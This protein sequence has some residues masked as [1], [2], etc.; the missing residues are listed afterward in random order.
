MELLMATAAEAAD[1][2]RVGRSGACRLI[3]PS[4]LEFPIDQDRQLAGRKAA[5]IRHVAT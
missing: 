5:S 2:L 1:L 4:Q 3:P